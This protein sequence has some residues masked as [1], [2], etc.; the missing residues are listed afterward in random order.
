MKKLLCACLAA[1]AL[2]PASC[3]QP[4]EP[5]ISAYDTAGTAEIPVEILGELEEDVLEDLD[6][7]S[8]V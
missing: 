5:D 2:L 7:K 8:V 3:A 4:V 6:R 1:L